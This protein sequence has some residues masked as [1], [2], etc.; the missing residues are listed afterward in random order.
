MPPI[1]RI[2]WEWNEVEH[3]TMGDLCETLLLISEQEEA[4]DFATSYAEIC[5][6]EST[7]EANIGYMLYLIRERKDEDDD[8]EAEAE[9]LAEL[10]GISPQGDKIGHTFGASSLGIGTTHPKHPANA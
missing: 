2:P 5:G 10:F 9:R 8:G 7:A 6:D 1:S 4:D 3:W